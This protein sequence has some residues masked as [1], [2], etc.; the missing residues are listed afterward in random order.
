MTV[1]VACISTSRDGPSPPV[2]HTAPPPSAAAVAASNTAPHGTRSSSAAAALS[3]TVTLLPSSDSRAEVSLSACGTH[4]PLQPTCT[5]LCVD[6]SH[7]QR[8]QPDV[9]VQVSPAPHCE[10]APP[11]LVSQALAPALS[12]S[13]CCVTLGSEQ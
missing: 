11:A 4:S 10:A 5:S 9:A 1:A 12:A 7:A 3:A 6:P 8:W 13:T 2:L